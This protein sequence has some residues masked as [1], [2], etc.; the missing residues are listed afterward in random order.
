MAAAPRPAGTPVFA[1]VHGG[2]SRLVDA[3]ATSSRANVECGQTV[4]SIERTNKGWHINDKPADAVILAVP[5]G[6]AGKLVS[7]VD[8][9]LPYASMALVTLALPPDT[10]LPEL[11]GF[12]VPADQGFA[13]KAA[14]FFTAKWPH[15]GG[16][17][18]IVRASLGRHG[19]TE[20]LRHTDESLVDLV[21]VELSR[22][23]GLAVPEPTGARVNRW[24]GALP[25][26][27]VG[28]VARVAH[29]RERLPATLALAGAAYDGVGIAA[30]ARSGEAAAEQ[31]VAALRG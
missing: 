18:V 8:I 6:P 23:I 15:L 14:T 9:D 11:S 31:V 10:V 19:Q 24:G 13:V 17:A 22:L 5:A 28:H 29:V 26:Y 16:D 20:V 2:L 12:L 4:R 1:S 30:C 3:L 25:Q 27:P 21:R 7:E